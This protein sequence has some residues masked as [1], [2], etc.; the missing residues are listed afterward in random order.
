[1]RTEKKHIAVWKIPHGC[2]KR[3]PKII[4]IVLDNI[5]HYTSPSGSLSF[6]YISNVYTYIIL[7]YAYAC[8]VCGCVRLSLAAAGWLAVPLDGRMIV[9]WHTIYVYVYIYS[10]RH[11]Q[12]QTQYKASMTIFTHCTYSSAALHS[13]LQMRMCMVFAFRVPV[14]VFFF[15]LS[16]SSN[17]SQHRR[18][19]SGKVRPKH[20]AKNVDN[21]RTAT[22][23][24]INLS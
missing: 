24:T 18:S 19:D 13:K 4:S 2:T 12:K 1:M 15:F 17:M 5:C 21:K 8:V 14:F 11:T 7:L 22:A 6:P 9:H 20:D 3:L 16:F 10:W 23:T